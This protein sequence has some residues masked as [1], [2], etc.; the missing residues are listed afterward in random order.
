MEACRPDK[1]PLWGST[2]LNV[3]IKTL[4]VCASVLGLHWSPCFHLDMCFS[5]WKRPTGEIHITSLESI[6][7]LT[8]RLSGNAQHPLL[9]LLG[10]VM[11]GWSPSDP[12]FWCDRG[13]PGRS[14]DSQRR[15]QT[16]G[17]ASRLRRQRH[18]SRGL[19]G[20]PLPTNVQAID[21]DQ[22]SGCVAAVSQPL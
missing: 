14:L 10:Q 6:P 20:L 12:W 21:R 7:L 8:D 11:D 2:R 1:E 3:E 19:G 4:A 9:E 13:P 16:P 15:F 18:T 17:R 22:R 5:A